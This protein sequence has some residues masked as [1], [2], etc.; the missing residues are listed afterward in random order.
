MAILQGELERKKMENCRL[1]LMYDQLKTDYNTM[2]MCFE[3]VMLDHKF[4]EVKG[5]EVFDGKFKEKE[6]TENGGVLGSRKD[7]GSTTNKVKEVKGQEV[8]DGKFGQKKR[9][10]NGGELMKRKFVDVGLTTNKV[11]EVKGK[12]VY[13][14]KCEKK[15]RLEN[16]GELVPR[17]C[18]DLVL[19]T[20]AETTMDHEAC[21]SSMRKR[22]SQDQL[23]SAMKSIGVASKELVLSKNADVNVDNVEATLMKSRVSIRARSEET[24]VC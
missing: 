1:K 8:S 23:G 7:L 14:G 2:R 3:K 22:R 10:K 18:K 5:K 16:G 12:E 19:L 15:K 6:R 13:N 24:M 20:N 4:K 21:S 17:Q 9:M 11:K